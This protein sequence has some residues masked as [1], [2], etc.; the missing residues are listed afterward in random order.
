MDRKAHA[1]R[2]TRVAAKRVTDI[3]G[4]ACMVAEDSNSRELTIALTTKRCRIV[5][6][7]TEADVFI[8]QDPTK[9][10]RKVKFAA[11]LKGSYIVCPQV[12]HSGSGAAIKYKRAI[13]KAR[14]VWITQAFREKHHVLL[15]VIDKIAFSGALDSRWVQ[16]QSKE[17]RQIIPS[18]LCIFHTGHCG[19][20]V[21]ASSGVLR[22]ALEGEEAE[23]TRHG[24][25]AQAHRRGDRGHPAGCARLHYRG[26]FDVLI[27]GGRWPVAGRRLRSLS[28]GRPRPGGPDLLSE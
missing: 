6:D 20:H 4:Q 26:F 21:I 17:D 16:L 8:A 25:A 5:Q 18:A 11:V 3:T 23:K 7:M 27:R 22:G 2:V 1:V 24:R 15:Q 9:V 13:S 12:V 28:R 19:H 14:K 10:G